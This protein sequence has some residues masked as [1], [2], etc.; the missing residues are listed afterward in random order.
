MHTEDTSL[1][2]NIQDERSSF[3]FGTY[4]YIPDTLSRIE[5]FSQDGGQTFDPFFEPALDA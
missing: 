3:S 5:R 2:G 4:S 1:L